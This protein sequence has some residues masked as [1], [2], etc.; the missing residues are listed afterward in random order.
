M[1]V[2]PGFQHI[3]AERAGFEMVVDEALHGVVLR[4]QFDAVHAR[5]HIDAGKGHALVAIDEAMVH[6]HAFPQCRGFFDDIRDKGLM[7]ADNFF[8]RQVFGHERLPG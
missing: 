5:K 8:Q 2:Q 7:N 1:L 6:R 4:N 3:L